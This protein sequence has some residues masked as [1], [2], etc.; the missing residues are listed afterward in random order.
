MEITF[1][2]NL[3][4]SNVSKN[5]YKMKLFYYNFIAHCNKNN[6]I[7]N[8]IWHEGL[9]GQDGVHIAC[10]LLKILKAVVKDNPQI[11]K[12]MM[13]CE[14][15]RFFC[16]L[17][18][19]WRKMKLKYSFCDLIIIFLKTEQRSIKRLWTVSWNPLNL[20]IKNYYLESC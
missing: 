8:A 15:T 14:R 4:K 6:I 11:T 2:K 3:S 9:C 5:I 17:K 16:L 12:L 18:V 10:A 19:L 7:Y 13:W 1:S 20:M